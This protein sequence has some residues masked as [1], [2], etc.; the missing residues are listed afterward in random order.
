MNLQMYLDHYFKT[1][2]AATALQMEKAT[3]QKPITRVVTDKETASSVN[4][5]KPHLNY[6]RRRRTPDLGDSG[7]MPGATHEPLLSLTLTT[8]PN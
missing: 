1:Y 8:L 6:E 2:R 3:R 4:C 7:P 5:N